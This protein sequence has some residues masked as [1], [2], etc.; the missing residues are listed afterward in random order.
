MGEPQDAAPAA[1]ALCAG[2]TPAR[3]AE[4]M[5]AVGSPEQALAHYVAAIRETLEETLVLLAEGPAGEPAAPPPRADLE[6][7]RA[8]L[9]AGSADFAAWIAAAGLRLAARRLVYFAHWITP[10][11]V[12]QRFTAR[13]FLAAAP[14]EPQ[15]VTDGEEVLRHRWVQPAEAIA[16]KRRGDIH[17]M[18]PTVR[19]LELLG[20]F[21]S[22]EEALRELERRPV[23][24]I[25]PKLQVHPDGSRTVIYPWDADYEHA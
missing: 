24:A 5:Q 4:R 16:L 19:N 18:D 3:A 14:P 20:S 7:L 9:R 25:L 13:F 21:A 12:P 2:L 8:G 6:A 17:L 11:V 15:V 1:L 23:P 10:E 22:T